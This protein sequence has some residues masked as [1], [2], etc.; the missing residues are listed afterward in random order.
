M[1]IE[2]FDMA[3][4]MVG[5]DIDMLTEI[6]EEMGEKH[7]R[8]GVS[9]DMYPLMGVAI[10][11]A[12][13]TILGENKFDAKHRDA[14]KKLYDEMADDMIRGHHEGIA[15]IV[16]KSLGAA[17][18]KKENAVLNSKSSNH[19]MQNVVEA[20]EH[21]RNIVPGGMQHGA[22]SSTTRRYL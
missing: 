14:F 3:I 15:G 11:D 16:A 9:P 21:R 12:V 5:P 10:S 19:N 4:D 1:Y 22:S 17:A 7:I 6:L 2:M 20:S 13:S 18:S 8:Y